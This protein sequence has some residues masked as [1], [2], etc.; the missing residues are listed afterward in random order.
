[1][2]KEGKLESSSSADMG[3]GR[4]YHFGFHLNVWPEFPDPAWN[5]KIQTESYK[6]R[7][8]QL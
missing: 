3:R 1:M 5:R 8:F 7:T 2:V 4:N 6:V